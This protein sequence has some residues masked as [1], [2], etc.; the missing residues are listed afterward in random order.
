MWEDVRASIV[1]LV[2]VGPPADEV[3]RLPA[4]EEADEVHEVSLLVQEM[5]RGSTDTR[6]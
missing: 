4:D 2:A 5:V 1:W 3:V 6:W